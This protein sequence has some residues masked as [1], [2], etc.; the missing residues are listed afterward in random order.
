MAWPSKNEPDEHAGN[1]VTL[2]ELPGI[3]SVSD[4]IGGPRSRSGRDYFYDDL[5]TDCIRLLKILPNDGPN[6]V[7][8]ELRHFI[9][10]DKLEYAALS[11]TWGRGPDASNIF[12]NGGEMRIRKNLWRFLCQARMFCPNRFDW[13]WI[14]A[15]CINQSNNRERMHQ[16]E[17][18]AKIFQSASSVIV[19]LGPRY[20]G[21]EAA[22]DYFSSRTARERTHKPPNI[23]LG[24]IASISI[25]SLCYR[26][27]WRRLWILQEIVFARCI[28]LMCGDRISPWQCF[29]DVLLGTRESFAVSA[30]AGP[31]HS[32][33]GDCFESTSI[34]DSP[35]MTIVALSEQRIQCRSLYELLLETR[36]LRCAD[37]LDKVYALLS[38][39]ESGRGDIQPDYDAAIA[40]LLH[41]IL[42]NDHQSTPPRSLEAVVNQ[43]NAL[44]ELFTL[45]PSSMIKGNEE[46][47]FGAGSTVTSRPK[48]H[49]GPSGSPITWWWISVHSHGPLKQAFWR[50]FW[51]EF[52]AD[53]A[54]LS[55]YDKAADAGD[56]CAL[57]VLFDR[58][59]FTLH[60][61]KKNARPLVLAARKGHLDVVR[62][63]LQKGVHVGH[64]DPPYSH[65]KSTRNTLGN[66][67]PFGH[68]AIVEALIDGGAE[69]NALD[70]EGGTPLMYAVTYGQTSIAKLLLDR[71][72][73]VDGG[74]PGSSLSK[75][76]KRGHLAIFKLLLESGADFAARNVTG[77]IWQSPRADE[78]VQLIMDSR[79]NRAH[80]FADSGWT[81]HFV[82]KTFRFLCEEPNSEALNTFLN[83]RLMGSLR[84]EDRDE[85][86][87]HGLVAAA[88]SKCWNNVELL[89][90]LGADVD[91]HRDGDTMLHMATYQGDAS[92]VKMLLEYGADVHRAVTS[93]R[94]GM[95]FDQYHY[96]MFDQPVTA[97]SMAQQK[98]HIEIENLLLDSICLQ[99]VEVQPSRKR[100]RPS[101]SLSDLRS[102]RSPINWLWRSHQNPLEQ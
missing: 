90:K 98:R 95:I 94:W 18:M 92:A 15:I 16:V 70:R 82:K 47:E 85:I 7:R 99:S 74:A 75:S 3:E 62:L 77:A 93:L 59:E 87:E 14:D 19:W 43:C 51:N 81:S 40:D 69:V 73:D 66:A 42:R 63:L 35:A 45:D 20:G 12:V 101:S 49:F 76:A 46:I 100:R 34:L 67:V 53:R 30:S 97:L 41:A 1:L 60:F 65:M 8:C 102:F 56:V 39:A 24:R 72:A 84:H 64:A 44:E 71:G 50:D 68:Y 88:R 52:P 91:T 86:S 10:D 83:S 17:L 96:H 13:L 32:R 37:Q 78:M 4:P 38:I 55:F 48:I 22:L 9:L 31:S 6:V 2:N 11:Y 80:N 5:P 25:A 57:E 58:A 21:S 28:W 61:N 33:A 79:H 36:F 26:P 89:L 29:R 27:Y 54:R 23:H